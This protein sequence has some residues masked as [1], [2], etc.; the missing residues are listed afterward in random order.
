MVRGI[1]Y[2]KILRKT[3]NVVLTIYRV[4]HQGLVWKALSKDG[5]CFT[6]SVQN[7]KNRTKPRYR[8]SSPESIEISS[9]K[10][11]WNIF[12]C[13]VIFSVFITNALF[14]KIQNAA[15]FAIQVIQLRIS[16]F[17]SSFNLN[18]RN[19][20]S[21]RVNIRLTYLIFVDGHR[22]DRFDLYINVSTT[23]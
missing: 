20:F 22:L 15:V 9:K 18:L 23:C 16:L 12:C 8:L 17:T 21:K 1:F 4:R 14:V 5:P 10:V 11:S 6:M 3:K 13:S 7:Y 19:V 2:E